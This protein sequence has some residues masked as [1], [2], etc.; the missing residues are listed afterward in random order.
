MVSD[1]RRFLAMALTCFGLRRSDVLRRFARHNLGRASAVLIKAGWA[2]PCR[3]RL[4]GRHVD[5]RHRH[6]GTTGRHR[7]HGDRIV[8]RR[9]V[10]GRSQAQGHRRVVASRRAGVHRPAHPFGFRDHPAG[11]AV[12]P[13]LP[14]A[15]RDHD[16]HRQLRPRR[17]RRRQIP[18]D[19]RCPRGRH[20]R[21][22]PDP[23]RDGPFHRDGQRGPAAELRRSWNG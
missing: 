14:D 10:R 17:A 1:R 22:P 15:G 2:Y 13:E 7:G 16:R 5:R 6:A 9:L 19:H 4:E 12:E 11:H 23:A 21:H 20:E 3:L 8:A 18:G